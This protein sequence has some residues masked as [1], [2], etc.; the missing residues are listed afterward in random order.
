MTDTPTTAEMAAAVRSAAMCEDSDKKWPYLD[1]AADYIL[2]AADVEL[3]LRREW[4]LGHRCPISAL[5]GDD[6]EMQCGATTCMKDFKRAPLAE[7]REHV[8]QRR[9]AAIVADKTLLDEA[10]VEIAA[11]DAEI[12]ELDTKLT[13]SERGRDVAIANRD[14]LG[15]SWHEIAQAIGGISL[16][17]CLKDADPCPECQKTLADLVT[18]KLANLQ[19]EIAELRTITGPK[20]PLPTCGHLLK[21]Q[22]SFIESVPLEQSYY[23]CDICSHL[24]NGIVCRITFADL[25]EHAPQV[26]A[27]LG[28][29]PKESANA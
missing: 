29:T 11:K 22:H 5:Y 21:A 10:R 7:L 16:H 12:A 25:I 9:Y 20:C 19:R 27:E 15:K 23:F 8:T 2:T 1:A 24:R 4:W 28:L 14:Q 6:G 13:R 26:A 3:T 18:S 17:E